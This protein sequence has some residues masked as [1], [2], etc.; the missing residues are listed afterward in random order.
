MLMF[1]S[2][3]LSFLLAAGPACAAPAAEEPATAEEA[4]AKVWAA[5]RF[6]QDKGA[7]GVASLDSRAGPWTWKDS[8]VFA[9]DCR[10]DRMIAHPIRPDLVGRPI[11]QI[12]DSNGK[13]VFSEL[14]KA[15]A[16]PRGGW[17]EYDWTRPGA[18]RASRKLSYVLTANIAF[19]T[20]I[21]VAAGIHDEHLA[22][23]EL[24]RLTEKIADP[25]KF[26]AP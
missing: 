1:R 15:G 21:Q 8:Y 22:L 10:R 20:G 12:T 16:L 7:S 2:C 25:A 13:Y 18:G 26:P 6:L 4:V 11:M 19:S 5:A 3:A 17:V 24:T 9:F 14:C 23:D